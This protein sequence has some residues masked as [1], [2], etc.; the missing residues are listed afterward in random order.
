MFELSNALSYN[1][2]MKQQTALPGPEK[3]AG[4][5]RESSGWIN[6]S[7]SENNTAGKDHYVKTQG[8]KAWELIRKAFQLT[9]EMPSLFVITP[10]TTVRDGMK[11]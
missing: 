8:E 10:F 7:G 5:C 11:S 9:E 2:M 1:Q 4:F 6:V 3:E